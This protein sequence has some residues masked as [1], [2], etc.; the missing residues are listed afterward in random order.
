LTV[1]LTWEYERGT[2][3]HRFTGPELERLFAGWED[4]QV[5]ENGGRGVA[6]ATQTGRIIERLQARLRRR[7]GRAA[8]LLAPGFALIYMLVN[9]TGA[10]IE[11]GEGDGPATL[12]M[13][14]MVVA[15]RP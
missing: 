8:D 5:S 14:L 1:P 11:K 7:L 15:R 2:L 12:P 9:L 4:V 6:W 13:N 10:A 3:E